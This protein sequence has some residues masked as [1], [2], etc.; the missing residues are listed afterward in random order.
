MKKRLAFRTVV[1]RTTLVFGLF[2]LACPVV[3]QFLI[4]EADADTPGTDVLEFVELYDG[5][6]GS[7]SLTGYVLVFYNG[8]ND[9]SYL[10][11]DL[12][13]QSTDA[14]GFFVAGNSGVAGVDLTFAN[15]TLQ[16]GADAVALYLGDASSFP[17][18][19]A[20]T[21]VNLIDALVYDTSDSDDAGLL[22]LLHAAQPQ[23]N[24]NA[25]GDGDIESNQRCP[26]GSG[27][28][29]NTTTY[30]QAAPSPGGLNSCPLP[31]VVV[32]IHA[33]QGSG[34]LSPLDGTNVTVSGIVTGVKATGF[35]LQAE[36]FDQDADF[37]TSEAVFV[38]TDT[39]V[40]AAAVVGNEVDVTGVVE[41]FAPS[42]DPLQPPMTEIVASAVLVISTGNPLP[43]AVTLAS[44]P[45]A[46]GAHDQLERYESMR[47]S[48]P[49]LTIVAPTGGTTTEASATATTN[50]VFFGVVPGQ[51]RP[52][53]EAG[54]QLPDPLP[55]AGECP[56][57]NVPRFD[58]NPERLRVDSDGIGHA[59]IEVSTGAVVTGLTGP[60]DYAFRTYTVVPD[61]GSVVNVTSG[62]SASAAALPDGD[63]LTLASFNVERFFDD[64]D[65]AGITEPILTPT[66]YANRL[67]KASLIVRAHLHA[68]DVIG[69]VEM[70]HL[71]AAED[72]ADQ[73]D[74]DALA[75]GDELPQYAAYLIE[76]NDVG[77]IDVGFLVKTAPVAPGAPR[78]VVDAV[79]QLGKS[80][81][82][83]EP[84]PGASLLN[85]R[86]PLVLEATAHDRSG[87]TFSFVVVVNHLRSLN[88]I[89]DP[90]SGSGG[91]ASGGDRV[92]NKRKQQAE[93]LAGI[94]QARQSAD[95][96]EPILLVGDFNAF[97]V[98]DGL[99]DVMGTILGQPTPANQVC[100]ASA[101]LVTANLTI[102]TEAAP[103]ERYSYSFDGNAQT[104]DHAVAN[105]ALLALS[106]GFRLDHARV[107]A[108]F[109]QSDRGNYTTDFARRL[110][111]H[112]PLVAYFRIPGFT[113][114]ADG[115]E[116]HDTGRWSAAVP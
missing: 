20:L 5:G 97:E 69:L 52:F 110:S 16:N 77:G 8:A 10:A 75:A 29:R 35:F 100:V 24:E 55:P 70:E 56:A 18:G 42:A 57:A 43:E 112:D 113:L 12:D 30:D 9:L 81:V 95:P 115:F 85:D 102:L 32:A 78:V 116:S 3:A 68:P 74:A 7:Q 86:P 38:F 51:Q 45:T 49:S 59:A 58:T 21:T 36:A 71:G 73:I 92:R 114:F 67:K 17:D 48:V 106:A 27:G 41:E 25:N 11:L 107:D 1:A 104:L 80:T 46:L 63:E 60:L 87:A 62:M 108:D 2:V 90:G 44:E 96:L 99:V 111:D 83:V 26:D 65:D 4:N 101:D 34:A 23:V 19:T 72:L 6:A 64:V 103:A 22:V 14:N 91:W 33:V 40:P 39:P 88:G 89:A 105:S 98:N 37:A 66:A 82:F 28:A 93:F 79:T 54:H 84:T 109:P 61:P 31:P 50:G 94:V 76:G 15:Q 53:R 47:V 13:G